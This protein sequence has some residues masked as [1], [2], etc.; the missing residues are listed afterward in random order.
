MSEIASRAG[1]KL[2]AV[3]ILLVAAYVLFKVVLGFITGLV[4]IAIVVVAVIAVI[5]A[6]RVL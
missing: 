5:W 4:W 3:T 1:R 2:L 6:T